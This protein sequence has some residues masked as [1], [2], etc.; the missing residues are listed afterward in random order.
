MCHIGTDTLSLARLGAASVVGLDFSSQSL[1]QARKLA[2]ETHGAGGEKLR[3]VEGDVYDGVSLLGRE[4]YDMVFTG[5][6]A[7]GWL[8][9]VSRW[10]RVVSGLLKPGG[11]FFIRE[12]HPMLW[13]VD[14]SVSEANPEE[15]L[16]L[17]F[18]YFEIDRPVINTEG[19]LYTEG[20]YDAYANDTHQDATTFGVSLTKEFNHGLGEIIQALIEAGLRITM[21]QEHDTVPWNALPGRMERG[22][23]SEYK[24]KKD[25]WRLPC[26][27][28][29]QAVKL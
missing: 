6:G 28:T 18:P 21:V 27:Y 26:T 29:I 17:S 1:K 7:L 8:P 15:Q 23:I 22:E 19:I 13:A 20:P 9:N 24:L 14:D 12:G 2:D 16:R 4:L 5:I 11:Q 3:Y 10:A 25:R